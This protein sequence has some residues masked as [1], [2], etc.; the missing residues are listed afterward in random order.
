MRRSASR[1]IQVKLAGLAL[2]LGC[3]TTWA[4]SPCDLVT[5]AEASRLLGVSAGKKVTLNAKS[6]TA[7]CVIR[8]T[9]GAGAAKPTLKFGVITIPHGEAPREHMDEE[10]GDEVPSRHG[11][12]WYEVSA[13][14]ADH[15]GDRR[16]VIHRDRTSLILDLHSTHQ[17]DAKRAFESIWYQIAE[18]LPQDRN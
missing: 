12:P 13:V 7:S 10:R 18:R 9:K 5:R 16:L 4:A 6:D 11:E 15:P 1:R 2:L 17:S 3:G 8:A 14:D